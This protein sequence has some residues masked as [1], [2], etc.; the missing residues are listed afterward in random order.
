MMIREIFN[1]GKR[2]ANS[3]KEKYR[4]EDFKGSTKKL[5]RYGI[6]NGVQYEVSLARTGLCEETLK[7]ESMSKESPGRTL[8]KK[9]WNEFELID[10]LEGKLSDKLPKILNKIKEDHLAEE[11]F[12]DAL[13][14]YEKYGEKKEKGESL[15]GHLEINFHDQTYKIQYFEIST[16]SFI[17]ITSP[18]VN[19]IIEGCSYKIRDG[20]TNTSKYCHDISP[21]EI[22]KLKKLEET[23]DQIAE[24]KEN[25]KPSLIS[26]LINLILLR[27]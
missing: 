9:R 15:K 27:N 11:I 22:K 5:V 13:E 20:N 2:I 6:V 12:H 14:L 16:G 25:N 19:I 3:G 23:L 4:L 24:E 18:E 8:I 26:Q 21:E 7:V 17:K 10:G 1:E